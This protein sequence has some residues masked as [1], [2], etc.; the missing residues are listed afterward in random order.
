M[1][2]AGNR[3]VLTL[4][5][6]APFVSLMLLR[7]LASATSTTAVRSGDRA[8]PLIASYAPESLPRLEEAI[9]S[10]E[11]ATE[12]LEALEPEWIHVPERETFNVNTP[13]DLTEAEERL[14]Q[15]RS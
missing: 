15:P 13:E 2:H 4:P 3:P 9:T 12:A 11:S 7:V 6:D 10:G 1:R 14:R 8:H 5:C